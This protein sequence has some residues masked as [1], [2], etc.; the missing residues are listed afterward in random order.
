MLWEPSVEQKFHKLL[1]QIPDMIRGI[2]ETRVSKKAESL[3]KAAG[4]DVITEKDMVDAFFA[5]T[6]GGFIPAMKAGMEELGVDVTLY[7]YQK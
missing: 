4:R 7:G 6:P 1:E 2:A 3:V 5:E